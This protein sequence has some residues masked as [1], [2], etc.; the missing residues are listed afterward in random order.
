MSLG[1]LKQVRGYLVSSDAV[2][3]KVPSE[4]IKTGWIRSD[5][6]FPCITI[7]Q[8]GGT[9]KGSLVYKTSAA[10]S[11]LR[12]ERPRFQIDIYSQ[13]DR[14]ETIQIA[15]EV[16]KVMISGGC[17]KDSDAEDYND[18]LNLY[19]KIQTYSYWKFHED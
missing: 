6:Q 9:D 18:E 10:G 14:L 7:V 15:D 4:K 1:A 8:V 5:D 2:I 13:K 11:K 17:V 16:V 12:T 19:R 3:T